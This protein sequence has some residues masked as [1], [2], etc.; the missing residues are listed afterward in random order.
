[1][2]PDNVRGRLPVTS[3]ESGPDAYS[4]NITAI[5]ITDTEAIPPEPVQWSISDLPAGLARRV[6]ADPESGCWRTGG[7]HDEDGYAYFAGEGAH[8]AAYRL[9]VGPIP[10]GHQIDHVKKRGCIW[11]D[12][13][14][15]GHLEPVTP[16]VNTMRGNSFAVANALKDACG[17]CGA[18]YDLFNTYYK[19][20]GARDCRACI[21][22]RV[23]E[24]KQRHPD[25]VRAARRRRRQ[26]QGGELATLITLA[27][28]GFTPEAI[29]AMLEAG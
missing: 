18:P 5:R 29:T 28:A 11:R 6:T 1:M 16:R 2:P 15:P 20:D 26:R 9:L 25:R 23:H 21:A 14:W 13:C 7:Y 24:Y 17:A 8:R 27:S 22:R 10:K 19:P 3:Q 12:C 4:A